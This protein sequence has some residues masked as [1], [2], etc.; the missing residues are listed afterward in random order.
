MN[1]RSRSKVG[2]LQCNGTGSAP[3]PPIQREPD[4]PGERFGSPSCPKCKGT[5]KIF[6]DC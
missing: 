4:V 1:E 5:E 3:P 2:C 6:A